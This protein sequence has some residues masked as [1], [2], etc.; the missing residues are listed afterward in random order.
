MNSS[1]IGY[2]VRL[3]MAATLALSVLAAMPHKSADAGRPLPPFRTLTLAAQSTPP[4]DLVTIPGGR[5]GLD[6]SSGGRATLSVRVTNRKG[7]PLAGKAVTFV[8]P[9]TGPGGSFTG[10]TAAHHT[11][12]RAHT[13]SGGGASAELTVNS[14]RGVFIVEARLDGT[15]AAAEFGV[16]VG[17]PGKPVITAE[18]ARQSVER[19]VHGAE[20]LYGPVLLPAG[21][22]YAEDT[23]LLGGQSPSFTTL[24]SP[25]WFFWI[26][27]DPQ[28]LFS[29]AVRFAAVSARSGA[30][31]VT[32]AQWWPRVSTHGTTASAPLLPAT[33]P[34]GALKAPVRVSPLR[35][36]AQTTTA[37]TTCFIDVLG[38]GDH[39]AGLREDAQEWYYTLATT[40][41]FTPISPNPELPTTRQNLV[42]W[43]NQAVSNPKCQK[44]IITISAHG[45][46]HDARNNG[47]FV[48]AN[49][50]GAIYAMTYD[51]LA[52]IL[53]P[54][55]AKGIQVCIYDGA[56]YSG[57]AVTD[58]SGYG[59]DGAIASS[60]GPNEQ[61]YF[62]GNID[63]IA[64]ARDARRALADI[65]NASPIDVNNYIQKNGTAVSQSSHPTAGPIKGMNAGTIVLP[66]ADADVGETVTVTITRPDGLPLDHLFTGTITIADSGVATIP[67]RSF[68]IPP[69]QT[70]A[71]VAVTGV[72]QGTTQLMLQAHSYG[73]SY[74]DVSTVTVGSTL[75]SSPSPVVTSV[76]GQ[77]IVTVTVHGA[78]EHR[79]LASGNYSYALTASGGGS[80][81]T[82]SPG[83]ATIPHG[84]TMFT[85]AVTGLAAGSTTFTIMGPGQSSATTQVSVLVAGL[86]QLTASPQTLGFGS[87]A[88][89]DTSM[90]TVT[91]TNTG[92]VPITITFV[93]IVGPPFESSD[94]GTCTT[95]KMLAPGQSCTLVLIFRPTGGGI[96]SG[97]PVVSYTANGLQG[98]RLTLELNVLGEGETAPLVGPI[99]AT[100]VR[101]TTTYTITVSDTDG[102][103]T[104]TTVDP[105]TIAWTNSNGCGAFG[106]S[107]T[108]ATWNHP[109]SNQP[110]ACPPEPVHPGTI[111]A[112][113]SDG[114]FTC[115]ATYPMGSAAGTANPPPGGWPCQKLK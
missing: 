86:P 105:V 91:L 67:S 75:T 108:T 89:G 93:A 29:H 77:N 37:A 107:G 30:R 103:S 13:D 19:I 90:R 51:E 32:N 11:V 59:F 34:A 83:T 18:R 48:L 44:V 74:S 16:S 63:A 42:D 85:F 96:V 71:M 27:D 58:M 115:T 38:P 97:N 76:G 22:A 2:D 15:A 114:F 78:A 12:L 113:V 3:A 84:Q 8:A 100:F 110:G 111:T 60:S 17:I 65:H 45:F 72:S 35:E 26:D 57:E 88:V 102:D 53:Q 21:G 36:P 55:A 73:L 95:T 7:T 68:E 66:N 5:S 39:E 6:I 31:T 61:A 4:A 87:V 109:D 1:R 82:I 25:S 70:Q 98:Q 80:I 64:W 112:V 99:V 69:G 54:L 47:G 20:Q 92:D 62:T 81:A 40:L 101:P 46:Q 104:D 10:G 33:A 106:G 41:H 94:A 28:A 9:A 79:L 50:P 52:Q 43:V 14:H 24:R 49:G 23:P 56:C